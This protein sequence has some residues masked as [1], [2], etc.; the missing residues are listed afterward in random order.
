MQCHFGK[1][2]KHNYFK[3]K[4]ETYEKLTLSITNHDRFELFAEKTLPLKEQQK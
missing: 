1:H 3:A 2:Y 4:R